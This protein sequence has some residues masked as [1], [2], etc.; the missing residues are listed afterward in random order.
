MPQWYRVIESATGWIS[1][2]CAGYLDVDFNA[3]QAGDLLTQEE[4]RRFYSRARTAH[5]AGD[6][7]GA[8][9][10]LGQALL[11]VLEGVPRIWSPI[12]GKPNPHRALLLTAFGVSP[13]LEFPAFSGQELA[14]G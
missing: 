11:C 12:V 7:R 14:S 6:Y 13:S 4:V 10:N 3:M 9:E 2:W 5:D 1:Q 8:L